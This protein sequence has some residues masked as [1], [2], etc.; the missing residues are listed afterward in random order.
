M[1]VGSSLMTVLTSFLWVQ[2]DEEVDEAAA[3]ILG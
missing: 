2:E 3:A 1:S